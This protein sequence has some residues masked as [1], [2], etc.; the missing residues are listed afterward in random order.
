MPAPARRLGPVPDPPDDR[1][2]AALA[3]VAAAV[4]GG[5]GIFEVVR[6]AGRALER[7]DPSKSPN[8]PRMEFR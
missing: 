3:E 4:A 8:H 1:D 5:E 2:L 6:S 7:R